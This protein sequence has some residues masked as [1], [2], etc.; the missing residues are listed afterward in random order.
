LLSSHSSYRERERI[1]QAHIGITFYGPL[2][3][4]MIENRSTDIT[5]PQAV[6]L[7][8]LGLIV[9]VLHW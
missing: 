6:D 9:L 7:V 1:A 5:V 4:G 3:F 8:L 2:I